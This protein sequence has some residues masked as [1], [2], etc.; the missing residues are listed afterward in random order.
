MISLHY[1]LMQTEAGFIQDNDDSLNLLKWLY[2]YHF[3][4]SCV[5]QLLAMLLDVRIVCNNV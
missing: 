5:Q 1:F 2:L 3:Y 4:N